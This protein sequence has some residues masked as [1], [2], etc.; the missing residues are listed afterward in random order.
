M[1][2]S[3]RRNFLREIGR[4][5]REVRAAG[6]AGRDAFADAEAALI[7]GE[8]PEEVA[9]VR[10]ADAL[11]DAELERYSRQLVL[12][13][14]SEAAQLR[15]RAASVLVIGAGALGSPVALYLAGAGV[16]RLGIADPDA[17]ELSNLHRQLLH[18]TPDVG[19]PKAHSAAA[20]LGFLNPEVEIAP[21]EVRLDAVNAPGLLVGHDLVVDCSD[22]FATRHA[23]NAACVAA[24]LPL[25]EGGVIGASGLVMA[26]RP[27][28]SACY[29]CAFPA[30]PPPGAEPSC[31]S[32]GIL[33]PAAGVVGSLQALEALKLVTGFAPPL[34]DAFLQVDLLRHEFT[35]V[36]VARRPDCPDCGEVGR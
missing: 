10:P 23:V 29:R 28:E 33:G 2:D 1:S 13:Q 21:Y 8:L 19:T 4:A 6:A 27:G 16:G 5:A 22:A 14:W 7:A 3:S 30:P 11:D 12:P 31:A 26:I 17:V 32:Q 18:F 34:L 24:R 35:R 36:G 20:K 25:V 9:A 15:L